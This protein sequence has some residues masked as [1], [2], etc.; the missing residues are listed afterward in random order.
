[1]KCQSK[2]V[3]AKKAFAEKAV[4][5]HKHRYSK[6]NPLPESILEHSKCNAPNTLMKVCWVVSV[7]TE[8]E[9]NHFTT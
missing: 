5:N 7:I 1:M 8:E 2:I 4:T 6:Q 9:V 3:Q